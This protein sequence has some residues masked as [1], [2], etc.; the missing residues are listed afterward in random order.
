MTQIAKV[1]PKNRH[2]EIPEGWERVT[3]G[4]VQ[5]GDRFLHTQTKMFV[6]VENYE[7]GDRIGIDSDYDLLIREVK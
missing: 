4:T 1:G 6:A 7:L 3:E 5:E 2:V